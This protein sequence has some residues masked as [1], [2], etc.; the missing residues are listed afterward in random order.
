MEYFTTEDIHKAIEARL[1][2]TLSPKEWKSVKILLDLDNG[3]AYLIDEDLDYEMKRI[4]K[5]LP[6][7]AESNETQSKTIADSIQIERS[8]NEFSTRFSILL[9]ER[10][11]DELIHE[12][13][14]KAI[15]D[16][17]RQL[18][19]E[20]GINKPIPVNGIR[21]Q[22]ISMG[23]LPMLPGEPIPYPTKIELLP[24][25]LEPIM[26]Q[27]QQLTNSLAQKLLSEVESHRKSG[28]TKYE[29]NEFIDKGLENIYEQVSSEQHKLT[30]NKKFEDLIPVYFWDVQYLFIPSNLYENFK[31]LVYGYTTFSLVY[32]CHPALGLAC[33]LSDLPLFPIGCPKVELI[34]DKSS[35]Q[36]YIEG[37]LFSPKALS[38]LYREIRNY[39]IKEKREIQG[40][41]ARPRYPKTKT[42][43][44]LKFCEGKT[45]SGWDTLYKEWNTAYPK[46]CYKSITRMQIAYY[47]AK[48]RLLKPSAKR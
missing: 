26:P 41:W 24:K 4:Q 17:A 11:R 46:W 28:I 30:Q 20:L 27:L 19:Q 16:E 47:K 3:K 8:S 7:L 9:S 34:K 39:S 5:L 40:E 15:I 21:D 31:R 14:V 25:E 29:L 18:R 44:L 1:K 6:L 37:Y 48:K 45:K 42:L 12:P 35:I 23:A 13:E 10:K 2:R 22:L 32:K 33:I 36:F 43:S 38:F